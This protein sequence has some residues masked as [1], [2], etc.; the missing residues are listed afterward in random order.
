MLGLD[1]HDCTS[2]RDTIFPEDPLEVGNVLTVEPGLYFQP[3]D[4]TVPEQYRGIGIRIEEDVVV[5]PEGSRVMTAALPSDPE[6]I[7]AWMHE[8]FSRPAPNLGL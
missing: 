8:L 1:V 6:E 7:E 5:T 2:A 3:N 4:L